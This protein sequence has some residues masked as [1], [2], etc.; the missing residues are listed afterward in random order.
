MLDVRRVERKGKGKDELWY[1]TSAGSMARTI[2]RERGISTCGLK[3]ERDEEGVR[4]L[5]LLLR[6]MVG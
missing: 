6:A 1:L 2:A 3:W 5:L 4:W